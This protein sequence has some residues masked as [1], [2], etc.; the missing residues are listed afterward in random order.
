M[1]IGALTEPA[2]KA[3]EINVMIAD[4]AIAHFRPYLSAKNPI[5]KAATAPPTR[6][7]MSAELCVTDRAVLTV[8]HGLSHI[9][10]DFG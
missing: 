4:Q 9:S 8:V 5:A 3:P 10:V 2:S 6:N 7:R 1:N